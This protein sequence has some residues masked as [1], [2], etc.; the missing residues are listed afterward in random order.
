MKK[1]IIASG[2]VILGYFLVKKLL[3]KKELQKELPELDLEETKTSDDV[4]EELFKKA[5]EKKEER[6]EERKQEK[7]DFCEGLTF[8]QCRRKKQRDRD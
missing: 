6:A 7:R 4:F 3:P 5:E 2:F 1:I 8:S